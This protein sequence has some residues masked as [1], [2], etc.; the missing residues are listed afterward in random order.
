MGFLVLLATPLLH[1]DTID[2]Y[3][4]AKMAADHLPGVC[5]GIMKDGKILR[6]QG[7]GFSNLESKTPVTPESQFRIASM[8]KQFCSASVMLLRAEGKIDIEAPI[9]TYL[10]D[11]PTSWD[12]IK[13]RHLMCHQSGIPNVTDLKSFQFSKEYSNKEFLDFLAPLPLDAT[14]G[15]TYHYNNSGYSLLGM[16]VQKAANMPL[17]DFVKTRI[18]EPLGM[19][20]SSYFRKSE[21]YESLVTGYD[22][23]KDHFKRSL[24]SRPTAMDGS[25]AVVTTMN[26]LAKWNAA[27]YTEKPLTTAMKEELWI[28]NKTSNGKSTVYGFGWTVRSGPDGKTVSHSG[29]TPGFTSNI[30]RFLDDRLTVIVLRNREIEGAAAMAQDIA[31]LYRGRSLKSKT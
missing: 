17:K 4:T 10:P 19:T 25:G 31:D 22:W 26:D 18:F 30:L 24:T 5:I 21:R 14:P 3:V 16:I 15:D 2:D 28:A 29:S 20:K 23:D 27:L 7:Y 13:V 8:S 6:A 11:A 12:P 1:A 9:K